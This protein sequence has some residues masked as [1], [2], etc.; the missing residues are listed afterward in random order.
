MKSFTEAYDKAMAVIATQEFDEEWQK[1]LNKEVQIRN[2][3]ANDGPDPLFAKGLD[4]IRARILA[5]PKGK[6]AA[7]I[8]AAA[9]GSGTSPG[10]VR[11]ATLKLLWHLYRG[12]KRGGQ[13]V[14]IYSPPKDF[15]TWIYEEII[16]N[17]GAYQPKLEATT[18]VYSK[19]ERG[20]MCAALGHALA[21]AQ[22]ACIKLASPDAKT[23][24]LIRDWFADEDTTPAQLAQA[25]H[26]LLDGYKNL[27][28]VLNSPT[29]IFSDEPID[30]NN[31]GWKDWAFVRRTERMNVV[32]IQGAFLDA[33][34]N[35]G[36][37]WICVE[38]IIH[39]LSHR[40][41][42]TE[43]LRYDYRGLKPVKTGLSF[44]RALRNADT[45]G[46][47]CVDLAGML[48]ATDRARTLRVA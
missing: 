46:Y 13:D 22:K 26:V 9:N 35:T 14:W 1:F 17:E 29:L 6:R 16:G 24:D 34:R 20:I 33:A 39:E 3:L 25:T 45:W 41:L 36:R 10:A 15:T 21:A 30:R 44:D 4:K 42:A 19:V 47:F 38:T 32:Y 23:R 12:H 8:L 37:L 27:S 48:S 5:H 43:D 18:E 11:A 31:G 2:L 28:V 7:A 40:I